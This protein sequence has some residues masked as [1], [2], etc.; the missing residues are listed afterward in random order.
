MEQSS[1]SEGNRFSASQEGPRVL[2]NPKV[3]YRIH[4]C[5]PPVPNLSQLDPAYT[6]TSHFLKIYHNSILPSTFGSFKWSLSHR[7]PHQNPVPHF[8]SP[9][10]ATCSTICS[11]T[12]TVY[13]ERVPTERWGQVHGCHVSFTRFVSVKC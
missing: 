5:P 4:K 7:F 9:H 6:P 1:S 11:Q 13:S 10:S 12:I 2:W 3:Q 8:L